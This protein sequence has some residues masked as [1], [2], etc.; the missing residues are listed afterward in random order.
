M[1]ELG[2]LE[3]RHEDFARRN[4]LQIVI[5][6]EGLGLAKKTQADFPHLVVLADEGR[7]LSI[8]AALVHAH[9]KPDGADI[10]AP[11][12]ILV[13]QKGIVRWIYRV[14]KRSRDCRRMRCCRRWTRICGHIRRIF[15][16]RSSSQGHVGSEWLAPRGNSVP[17]LIVIKGAD[18]GK[19]FELT[20]DRLTA[21]RDSANKVR[22]YDT[23]ASRRHAEFVRT[24]EGYRLRDVGTPT[25][26]SST[27]RAPRT[28]SFGP[29]IRFASARPFSS[30][31]RDAP[32]PPRPPRLPIKSISSPAKTSNCRQP[33]FA[34]LAKRRAAASSLDQRKWRAN[35]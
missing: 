15:S 11:T 26:L 27:A 7:G 3:R 29:A 34:P 12:T 2:Q 16:L 32:T 35:G 4:I 22:L 31:A 6:M 10:D 30:S 24:P 25:A 14:R 28:F 33:S 19:Q 20:G 1:I 9:A 17:R 8:A 18:E 21:G 13:D 5:S 23:E